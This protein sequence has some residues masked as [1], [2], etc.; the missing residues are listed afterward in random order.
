M[1]SLDLKFFNNRLVE[2]RHPL[3]K[4][5]H[6]YGEIIEKYAKNYFSYLVTVSTYNE[7]IQSVSLYILVPEIGIDYQVITLKIKDIENVI[8]HYYTLKTAQIETEDIHV[9]G[10]DF[11][12]VEKVLKKHLESPL[13][14]STFE[15]LVGQVDLKRSTRNENFDEID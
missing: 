2:Y 1:A 13:S 10:N 3:E 9:K 14:N 11:S 12:M 6:E 5:L 15:F 8:L 4:M 7:V